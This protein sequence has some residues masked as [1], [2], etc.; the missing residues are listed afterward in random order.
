MD[1]LYDQ[2]RREIEA[3]IA[4]GRA[5]AADGLT[6]GEAWTL[7]IKAFEAI[8]KIISTVNTSNADKR[9]LAVFC[10]DKFTLA[11]LE[12]WD[13]PRIP[14]FIERGLDRVI[15]TAVV[16]IAGQVID[17]I[18]DRFNSTGWPE[19]VSLTS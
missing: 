8:V 1:K 3:L 18:V 4:E 5:L 16:A 6:L 14:N 12:A 9:E 11:F 19:S 2:I 10:V 7:A 15:H 13:I 17:G